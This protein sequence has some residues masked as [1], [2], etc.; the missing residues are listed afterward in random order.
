[1]AVF[2]WLHPAGWPA[3]LAATFLVSV[4]GVWA[5]SRA[6]AL[7]ARADDGRVVVDEVAGQLL[8]LAPLWPAGSAGDSRGAFF[9]WVVTAFVAFRVFDIAKPGPVG[10]AERRFEGGV[11]VMADDWIAGLLAAVVLA[12][13]RLVALQQGELRWAA[14]PAGI[15]GAA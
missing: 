8:A 14:L 12:A 15:G 5:A 9:A 11:G 10:W 3:L 7:Y 2:W 4:A 6:E 13:L 1:M